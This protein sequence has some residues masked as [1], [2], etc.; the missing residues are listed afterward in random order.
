MRIP[1]SGPIGAGGVLNGR[2]NPPGRLLGVCSSCRVPHGGAFEG[3]RG[4]FCSAL[5][6]VL[7]YLPTYLPGYLPT[8]YLLTYYLHTYPP[9]TYLP[10]HQVP[11]YLPTC[12]S[13]WG[14]P[15]SRTY[16]PTY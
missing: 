12:A 1:E 5:W 9:S 11:T 13:L 15:T 3:P 2:P 4:G 8:Y 6:A 10:T 16:R 14:L 7:P